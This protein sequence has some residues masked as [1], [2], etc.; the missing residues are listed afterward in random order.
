[1]KSFFAGMVTLIAAYR[2]KLASMPITTSTLSCAISL[3]VLSM[4]ALVFV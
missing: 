4:V 1:M 3:R 2:S